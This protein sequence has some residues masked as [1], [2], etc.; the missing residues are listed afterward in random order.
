MKET[1]EYIYSEWQNVVI[2]F[3]LIAWVGF[4]MALVSA[5]RSQRGGRE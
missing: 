1:L 3:A 4:W 2:T 5:V